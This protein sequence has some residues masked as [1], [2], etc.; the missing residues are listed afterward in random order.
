MTEKYKLNEKLEAVEVLFYDKDNVEE[1][2]TFCETEIEDGLVFVMIN[3]EWT[4]IFDGDAVVK[5]ADGKIDLLTGDRAEEIYTKVSQTELELEQVHSETYDQL[6]EF[7][8]C[9]AEKKTNNQTLM[10]IWGNN[11]QD[12]IEKKNSLLN[13]RT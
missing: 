3:G 4:I 10:N 7:F 8:S 2:A 13:R 9:W 12:L 5:R 6:A 1:L 11:I